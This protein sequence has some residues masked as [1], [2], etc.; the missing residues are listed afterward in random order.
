MGPRDARDP[1]SHPAGAAATAAAR[2]SISTLPAR[3]EVFVDQ[4]GSERALRVSWHPEVGLVVLS[5]WRENRCVGTFR[6][7]PDEVPALVDALVTG[8]ATATAGAAGQSSPS[9]RD[10]G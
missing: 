2:A 6:L 9:V 1:A 4:R 7:E 3:G 10:V 8:L 5:L